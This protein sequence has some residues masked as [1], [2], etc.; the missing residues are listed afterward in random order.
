MGDDRAQIG[1]ISKRTL[2]HKLE[3]IWQEQS[4]CIELAQARKP[5]AH[6]NGCDDDDGDGDGTNK[7]T[8]IGRVRVT[9]GTYV[10]A[11]SVVSLQI[12]PLLLVGKGSGCWPSLILLGLCWLAN[13]LLLLL[14]G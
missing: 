3:P 11:R 9:G 2:T 13:L 1:E 5:N 14:S 4:S 6:S 12:A 10:L 7:Q 8:T